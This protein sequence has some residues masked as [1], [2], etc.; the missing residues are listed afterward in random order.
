MKVKLLLLG[1]C[2]S[3]CAVLT[4]CSSHPKFKTSEE[5]IDACKEKLAEL[6]SQKS[7]DIKELA[8]LTS[9][10]LELQDSAY[11]VF[12]KDSTVTLK[13][14]VALA[15]FLIS[16]SIRTEITRL[17]LGSPRTLKDVMY[18]KINSV[19]GRENITKSDTYKD[20]VAYFDD[21]DKVPT[22]MSLKETY[23]QYLHVL[24]KAKKFK[25]ESDLL[26]FIAAEDKCFR[27]LMQDLSKVGTTQ[28]QKL[29][30]KTGTIFD[31]FYPLISKGHSELNDRTMLYLT[32]RFN[33]RIIQNAE[34][35]CKDVEDEKKLDKE[36]MA[37]YRWMLIQPY[38]AIDDYSA[39]V[40]T[41]QQK[42]ELLD[43][44]DKLPTTLQRLDTD[45][46][47]KQGEENVTNV[48]AMYFLKSF[49]S[50]TL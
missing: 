11:S 1:A 10:W 38:M 33:R 46:Y 22:F 42:R 43:I 13:N 5:A 45:K 29:T 6:R 28:L 25:D 31:S 34:A 7:V 14:P 26:G 32:M 24:A 21:L 18:L 40:L 2:I 4:G 15:Y 35:C 3:I 8:K 36:Q 44:A 17:A 49:L 16:D 12:S 9:G 41:E 47:Q 39:S 48:L 23:P 19:R 37:N 27:S 50:T 30:E 20:A